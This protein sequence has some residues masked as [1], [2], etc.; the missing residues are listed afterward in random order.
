MAHLPELHRQ[1]LELRF[2]FS[3]GAP[4]AFSTIANATGLPEVEV[5]ELVT[6]ALALLAA[7]LRSVED[8][9]AA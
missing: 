9:R 5:R 7:D 6:D 3:D 4:A 1:V 8:M 2:G